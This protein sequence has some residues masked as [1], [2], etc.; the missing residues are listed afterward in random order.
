[1]TWAEERVGPERIRGAYAWRTLRAAGTHIIFGSD[2]PGSDHSI[3]YGLHAAVTRRDKR[4]QPAEGWY[5]EEALTPEEA[6]RAYT[7]WAAWS[8]FD[9]TDGGILAPGRRADITVIDIDPLALPLDRYQEILDGTVLLTVVGGQI[10][11]RA[12][13]VQ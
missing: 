4:A 13:S 12:P 2:F 11:H 7:S 3:F 1:M 8:G 9:E 10:A 5:P 6:V